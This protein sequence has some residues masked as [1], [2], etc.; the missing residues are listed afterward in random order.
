M[1]F[2]GVGPLELVLLLVIVFLVLGPDDLAATGKKIGRF[3]STVRKSEFWRGVNDVSKELRS[4]PTTLMREAEFEEAKKEIENEFKHLKHQT[5]EFNMDQPRGPAP[6][7]AA[8][9][10]AGF[11][12]E[13]EADLENQTTVSAP[14]PPD[15][16]EQN[17]QT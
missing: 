8:E 16:E 5:Q 17:D 10:D 11:E 12:P 7:A 15:G 2:L 9:V 14:S 3:L 13:A 4:L 1:D 6:A